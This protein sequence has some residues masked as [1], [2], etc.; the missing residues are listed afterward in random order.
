MLSVGETLW[1][2]AVLYRYENPIREYERYDRVGSAGTSA[3]GR[4][5]RRARAAS[6]AASGYASESST[7][8]L[9]SQSALWNTSLLPLSDREAYERSLLPDRRGRPVRR[10]PR[11]Q[12]LPA[13]CGSGVPGVGRAG[14]RRGPGDAPHRRRR[15][16]PRGRLRPRPPP[17]I[18]RTPPAPPPRCRA[19]RGAARPGAHPARLLLE[20]TDLS[21]TEVAFA[22][23]FSSIR[24]FNETVRSV[25]A[26]TPGELRRAGRRA[27]SSE[28]VGRGRYT[29]ASL[30]ANRSTPRSCCGS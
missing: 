8:R 12:A 23:G 21:D 2:S 11:V 27:G 22:A 25:F 3:S 13:E 1:P 17:R 6:G 5:P 19:R 28:G 24:Q 10:L 14:R 16:R 18:H 4:R 20:A 30:T 9:P 26:A 7:C 29:S 15:R